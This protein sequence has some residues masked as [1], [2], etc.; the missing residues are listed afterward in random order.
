MSIVQLYSSKNILN[1]H[2][3]YNEHIFRLLQVVDGYYGLLKNDLCKVPC[4]IDFICRF[5]Y[6]LKDFFGKDM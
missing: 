4:E 3:Q 1:L 6:L 5:V 2:L